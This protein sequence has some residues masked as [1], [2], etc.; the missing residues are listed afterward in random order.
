VAGTQ[1]KFGKTPFPHL[2]IGCDRCHGPTTAHLANPSSANIVDPENLEPNARDSV[3]EQCHLIGAARVLNPGKRFTDFKAGRPL[4]ET[5]TIYHEQAPTGTEGAFKVIS[6]SEQLALSKCRAENAGRM[7]CG[8]CHDPHHEPTETVSYYRQK[9]L[10]CHTTSK[11]AAGH[12]SRTSDCIGCH[13]PEKEANDGGHS[14][15]RDHRIQKR[16]EQVSIAE[17]KIIAPWGKLPKSLRCAI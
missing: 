13:M 17:A 16:P 12:P 1:N 2:A 3:C 6:H 9:C 10:S 14:A 11:F 15:F 7:W 8:T 5:F 4:E